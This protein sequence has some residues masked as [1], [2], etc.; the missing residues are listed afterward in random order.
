V[1]NFS[2][3]IYPLEVLRKHL[4]QQPAA[5]KQVDAIASSLSGANAYERNVAAWTLEQLLGRIAGK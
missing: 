1:R 4:G 5:L 3:L 2:Y